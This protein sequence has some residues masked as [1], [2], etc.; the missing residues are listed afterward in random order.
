MQGSVLR[1]VSR[2]S[3]CEAGLGAISTV[4]PVIVRVVL[5]R[6]V[7]SSNMPPFALPGRAGQARLEGREPGSNAVEP[8]GQP[9]GMLYARTLEVE[10]CERAEGTCSRRRSTRTRRLPPRLPRDEAEAAPREN[11][12]PER[13]SKAERDRRSTPPGS[14]SDAASA[15]AAGTHC[16]GGTGAAAAAAEGGGSNAVGARMVAGDCSGGAASVA[17]A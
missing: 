1:R 17:G 11:S 8:F 15:E 12:A 10:H 4:M 7:T 16:A 13:I 5:P 9:A 14:L 2:V 3:G 6:L